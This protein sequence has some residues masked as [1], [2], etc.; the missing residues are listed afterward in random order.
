[1]RLV[2]DSLTMGSPGGLA[3][4]REL[5]A[6][7]VRT[8]PAEASIVLIVP[9]GSPIAAN[10]SLELRAL[11]RPGLGWGRWRWFQSGLPALLRRERADVL[12][13]MSG[14]LSRRLRDTCGLITT[15][16]NMWPFTP[17]MVAQTPL[18]SAMRLKIALQKRAYLWGLRLADSVVLHSRHALD[19]LSR[20]DPTLGDKTAVVLTGPPAGARLDD[21]DQVPPPLR[22]SKPYFLYLSAMQP[23]KNHVRLIEGFVMVAAALG[24]RC[25]D[26][27]IAG[28][29][30]DAAYVARVV[31]AIAATGLGERI[32][33]LPSVTREA[34]PP[35]IHHAH[36]NIFPS[37]CETN[38][39]V[40]AE[41]LGMR[42]IMACSNMPP[43][44]E[45]A[46]DAAL[47]FDPRD[48]GAIAS[49]L[50]RLALEPALRDDLRER[51]RRRA[52]DLSWDQCGVVIWERARLAK[53]KFDERMDG[54]RG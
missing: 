3:L 22:G 35:L 14:Q 19:V 9:E 36:G 20:D 33:Y 25:P 6:A 13:S 11:R 26:L 40:Q 23:Y 12:F 39:V 51:S 15:V 32:V 18:L 42:G 37:L 5:S 10:Q 38:S 8:R 17:E 27:V 16:N 31:S 2:I 44:D 24:E 28:L 52:R 47:L 21:G 49:A 4:Q 30:A 41:I 48:A 50:T 29:P 7:L 45:V 43:M 1:L 34:I 53:Q 46:G 54:R